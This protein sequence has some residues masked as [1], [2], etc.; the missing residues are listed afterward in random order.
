VLKSR[1]LF[2]REKQLENL[3]AKAKEEGVTV[4]Q[5]AMYKLSD[6]DA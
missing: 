2:L 6:I 3:R 1:E 5:L 4:N